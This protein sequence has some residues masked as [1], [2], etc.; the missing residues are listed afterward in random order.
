MPKKLFVSLS[1]MSFSTQ[2]PPFDDSYNK[3][4]LSLAIHENHFKK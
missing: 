1:Y 4:Y 2:E 3:Y